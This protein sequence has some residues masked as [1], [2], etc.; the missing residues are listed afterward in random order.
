MPEGKIPVIVIFGP[1]AVG[2]TEFLLNFKKISE[3]INLD[4]LQVYRY[5]EIGT[6][7]PGHEITGQ[8]KH[9]L[10]GFL[11]PSEEF[12]AGDFVK[13][14]DI[15]CAEIYGRGKVPL[16]SGGNAFFLRNFIYGMPRAPKADPETR[17]II[18]SRLASEGQDALYRELCEVDPQYASGIGK[19]DLSRIT[20][21][22]EVYYSSGC[23]LSSYKLP[24]EPRKQYDMLLV[25]LNREREELYKRI[26][27]RVDQMFR[28]GLYDEFLELRKRGYNPES[29]GM[30]G[31]GYREFFSL[32]NDTS[33]TLDDIREQVKKNTR[34][35]A[36]RQITFFRKISNVFWE[37]PDNT[38]AIL[39]KVSRF[40]LSYGKNL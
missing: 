28:E 22:L 33:L 10:T 4:S 37:N 24:S 36:K 17:K 16:V 30:S 39:E 6:A 2:K 25:G 12:T 35:Y 1:T 32:E 29:P 40:L 13:N 21:A 34:H 8:I 9:H 38:D 23:P 15:L 31:I 14:G 7:S 27:A 11:D 3:I 5:M 18:A 20:R 26:E 19:N